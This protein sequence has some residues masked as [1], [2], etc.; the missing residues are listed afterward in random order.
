[1]SYE[2]IDV[3]IV[4][5]SQQFDKYNKLN[6]IEIKIDG[7]KIVKDLVKYQK[8]TYSFIVDGLLFSFAISNGTNTIFIASN[9]IN[10]T[11]DGLINSKIRKK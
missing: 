5:S 4:A 10:S 8:F 9:G 11:K 1:M 6:R 3:I 2:V 7:N